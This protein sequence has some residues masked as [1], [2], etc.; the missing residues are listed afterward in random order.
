LVLK[1]GAMHTGQRWRIHDT[2]CRKAAGSRATGQKR[3]SVLPCKRAFE[4]LDLRN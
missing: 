4:E 2:P 3:Q 1:I